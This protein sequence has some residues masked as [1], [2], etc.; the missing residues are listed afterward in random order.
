MYILASASPRRRE[1]LNLITTDFAVDVSNC[2]EICPEGLS[3]RKCP[4]YLASLKAREVASRHEK[5][6]VIIAADTAVFLGDRMLGKPADRDEARD[7]LRSL[8]GNTHTVITGCCVIK[9]EKCISFSVETDVEFYPLSEREIETYIE[10]GECYDKAG[11]Y[12]IQSGGA[13]LVRKINGDY[14]NVVG[15]PVAELSRCISSL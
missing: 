10:T 14:F 8:S 6:D 3:S 13:L 7:M 11:A 5:D 4:E 1:L 2:E 9:G 15:L 12:G